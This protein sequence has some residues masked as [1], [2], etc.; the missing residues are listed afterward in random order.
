VPF[1][2]GR[3][4]KRTSSRRAW[5]ATWARRTETCSPLDCRP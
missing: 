2:K 3:P 4:P 5:T 1:S